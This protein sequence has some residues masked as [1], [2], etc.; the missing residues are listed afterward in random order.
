MLILPRPGLG[1]EPA[2]LFMWPLALQA[3]A[4]RPA[5][6]CD[7]G[8]WRPAAAACLACQWHTF[9]VTEEPILSSPVVDGIHSKLKV[10][11]SEDLPP[12][13]WRGSG[14]QH[15]RPPGIISMLQRI[16]REIQTPSASEAK[17]CWWHLQT[18]CH[19][20]LQCLVPAQSSEHQPENLHQPSS[21]LLWFHQCSSGGFA[22]ACGKLCQLD[23]VLKCH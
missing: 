10:S 23:A 5:P 13:R 12:L 22:A 7:G 6:H 8:T 20:I 3:S 2:A 4:A 21:H 9:S 16:H 1:R 14:A 15:P 19:Q 17:S 18:V 11:V